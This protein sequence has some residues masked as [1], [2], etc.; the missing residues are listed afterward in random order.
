MADSARNNGYLDLALPPGRDHRKD[1]RQHCVT[2]A[3]DR[4]P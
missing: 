4:Q 2:L 3:M 1:I